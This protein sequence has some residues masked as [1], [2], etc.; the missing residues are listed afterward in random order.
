MV[1]RSCGLLGGFYVSVKLQG[2]TWDCALAQ[3]LNQWLTLSVSRRPGKSSLEHI[4]VEMEL[5]EALLRERYGRFGHD[6]AR[7]D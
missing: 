4:C 5:R 1:D 2:R 7:A 3:E 6:G